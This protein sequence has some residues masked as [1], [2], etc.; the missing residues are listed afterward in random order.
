MTKT[1]PAVKPPKTNSKRGTLRAQSSAAKTAGK[2]KSPL[3]QVYS[4][5][6]KGK[7]YFYAWRGGP[8]LPSPDDKLAFMEALT[9]AWAERLEPK[10][11]TILADLIRLYQASPEYMALAPST[12]AIRAIRLATIARDHVGRMTIPAL[13]ARQAPAAF[14]ALRNARAD[15][16]RAAD[17]HIEAVSVVLNWS[18]LSGWVLKNPCAKIP[19]LYRR[20]VRAAKVWEPSTFDAIEPLITPAARKMVALAAATGMRRGDLQDLKWTEVMLAR[21]MIR[22]PTNKSHGHVVAW[23][24]LGQYAID[25]LIALEP[26]SKGHV[27]LDESGQPWYLAAMT[28]E[29][30]T[31]LRHLNLDLHLNDLRGTYATI[32]YASGSSYE[33]IEEQLGWEPGQ[34]RARRRDYAREESVIEALAARMN[35]FASTA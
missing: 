21:A 31:A 14:M 35:S 28:R 23:I 27:L 9:A 16:P 29:I 5:N 25:V 10:R 34:A 24:P 13:E 17:E 33:E 7:R 3:D 30:N 2:A 11:P 20:G 1:P 19:A 26:K 18:I 4:V 22:R 15:T 8:S 12:R 32:L 6:A